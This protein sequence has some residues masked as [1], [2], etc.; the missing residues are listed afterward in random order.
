[1]ARQLI[2]ALMGGAVAVLG[3][4]P[5]RA[6]WGLAD[7]VAYLLI[8]V[9]RRRQR[10]ADANIAVAFPDASA[11]ER[12]CIRIASVRNATRAML[13]LLK[14]PYLPPQR[15]LELL[16]LP[17]LEPIREAL[18]SGS[19]VI[20]ITSHY[21]PWEWTGVRL[22]QALGA[23]SYVVRDHAHPGV[24]AIINRARACCG[25]GIIGRDDRLQMVRVLRAGEVLGIFPDQ[26][27]AKGGIPVDFLGRPAWTF[28]GPAWLARATGARVFPVF[29]RRRADGAFEADLPPEVPM[30]KTADRD[31]DLA[32][33]TRRINAAIEAG[34]RQ[35][36]ENWL[37]LHDRWKVHEPPE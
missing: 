18:A 3:M 26:H 8:A 13:E 23:V 36:P 11:A 15:L 17:S 33:N 24:A 27:A 34:I 30:V 16:P 28:R 37:W 12:R 10:L 20:I 25:L 21:G 32:E 2:Y 19:G 5:L 1:M 31:A 35:A 22:G 9:A 6:V 4:L 29:V 14:L 7:L